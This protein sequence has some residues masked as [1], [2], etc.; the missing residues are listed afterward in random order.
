MKIKRLLAFVAGCVPF[1]PDLKSL[2]QLLEIGDERTLKTYL[3]YLEDC[4][5]IRTVTRETAEACCCP[6]VF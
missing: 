2:K 3:K 4:G 6:A 1:T 5:V